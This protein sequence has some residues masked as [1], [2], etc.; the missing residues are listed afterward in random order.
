MMRIGALFILVFVISDY[1]YAWRCDCEKKLGACTAQIKQQGDQILI[2]SSVPQCSLVVFHAD[3]TPQVTNVTEGISSQ[4]WLGQNKNPQLT[5]DSC[6]IC[7]DENYPDE[8]SPDSSSSSADSGSNE[9]DLNGLWRIKM[10][11]CTTFKGLM[12]IHAISDGNLRVSGEIER[13]V[14][15]NAQI[16]GETI[17]FSC[18]Y[19][20]RMKSHFVGKIH[21]PT[22]MS[23]TLTQP[24]WPITCNWKANK[25]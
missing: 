25:E 6:T 7:K 16:E 21:S 8:R 5:I 3:G 20:G 11:S 4:V 9:Q 1:A 2:S 22:Y 10:A 24:P 13:C 23:G 12:H 19:E 17:N 15:E 18:A 14:F